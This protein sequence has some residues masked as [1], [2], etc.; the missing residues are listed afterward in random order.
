MIKGVGE[1]VRWRYQYKS[2]T[3]PLPP[4]QTDTARHTKPQH[5]TQHHNATHTHR[6]HQP[7]HRAAHRTHNTVKTPTPDIA[8]VK[9]PSHVLLMLHPPALLPPPCVVAPVVRARLELAA[10]VEEEDVRGVGHLPDEAVQAL[11]RGVDGV[12]WG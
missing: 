6:P 2:R 3:L 9:R 1:S 11:W 12:G 10:L 5:P 8:P 7:K 4:A